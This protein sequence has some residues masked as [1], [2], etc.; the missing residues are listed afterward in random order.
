MADLG[1]RVSDGFLP[2]LDKQSESGQGFSNRPSSQRRLRLVQPFRSRTQKDKQLQ[3]DPPGLVLTAATPSTLF[4]AS[5]L[6]SDRVKNAAEVHAVDCDMML[7]A[8]GES[9]GIPPPVPPRPLHFREREV[10]LVHH[11]ETGTSEEP[12]SSASHSRLACPIVQKGWLKG[13]GKALSERD[14][15]DWERASNQLKSNGGF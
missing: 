15:D 3:S 4:L 6:P 2:Y 13:K 1:R 11:E 8:A 10:H 5:D 7:R 14:E 9:Y 12:M